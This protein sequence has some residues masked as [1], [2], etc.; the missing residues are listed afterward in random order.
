M[1]QPFTDLSEKPRKCKGQYSLIQP[2]TD[3][4][5]NRYYFTEC[6]SHK[7]GNKAKPN[8]PH[9]LLLPDAQWQTWSLSSHI[10]SLAPYNTVS[11]PTTFAHHPSTPSTR[12]CSLSTLFPSVHHSFLIFPYS[13]PSSLIRY[14]DSPFLSLIN[15]L[16]HRS[17]DH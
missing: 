14:N 11:S 12:S 16:L 5:M 15:R 1:N 4:R 8:A 17:I 6:Q 7:V 2:N 13:S 10:A 9:S 3:N